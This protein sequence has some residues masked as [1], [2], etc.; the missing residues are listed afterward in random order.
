[1]T[2]DRMVILE[3]LLAIKRGEGYSNNMIKDVLDKYSYLDRQNRSFIKRVCEGTL[4]RQIELDYILDQFSAT[5][6]RKMKPVIL[7]IL[8]MGVYQLK[9]MDSVPASAVCNEA[10]KLAEKKGFRT[11]KGFVNGVLRNISRSLNEITY[12]DRKQD[13]CTYLSVKYSMPKWLVSLFLKEQGEEI[14]EQLLT[15]FLEPKAVT[16]R[17]NLSKI[18]TTDLAKRLEIENV[19]TEPAPY[20]PYALYLKGTDSIAEIPSFKEGCFQIQ[21]ISSMLVCA[22]A[23]IS[24]GSQVLDVCAAP[25]GKALHAADLLNQL[26]EGGHVTAHDLTE[27]KISLI[28]E[29]RKRCGFENISISIQD[30]ASFQ[31]AEAESADILLADLPCSGFGIIGKKSDI[32]YRMT[33]EKLSSLVSLQREILKN[34]S[35]YVK[36]GGTLMFSTCTI[37]RAENEENVEWIKENLPFEAV[38]LAEKLPEGMCAPTAD[39][40]YIQLLPGIHETDGFFIARFK[41]VN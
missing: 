40:G 15:S 35:R 28:E 1:M 21:D 17:V 32:K 29:N 34:V 22:L 37:H 5:K 24:G 27:A 39:K 23:G 4:E 14:T 36:P 18:L 12:P 30:A 8:E 13:M 6:T 33:E 38:S 31:E 10:V 11:L 7:A 25:G 41:K 19:Q 20:L 26:A 9:Y 3:T 2:N 16:A